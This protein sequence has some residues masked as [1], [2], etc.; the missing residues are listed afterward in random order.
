MNSRLEEAKEQI[1]D[2]EDKRMESNETKQKREKISMQ[3][4]IGLRELSNS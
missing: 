4:E 1:G 2:L 3:Y